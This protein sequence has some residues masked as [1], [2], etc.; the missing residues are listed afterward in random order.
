MKNAFA[1]LW[2]WWAN[3]C[4][5][6]IV[7]ILISFGL[8][9]GFAG[10]GAVLRRIGELDRPTETTKVKGPVSYGI[11]INRLESCPGDVIVTMRSHPLVGD[12]VVVR[13]APSSIKPENLNPGIRP[14]TRVTQFLPSEIGP[15]DWT[16]ESGVQSNCPTRKRWDLLAEFNLKVLP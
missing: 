2:R 12:R 1:N 15:G 10:D 4:G 5:V 13:F 11:D 8:V 3:G 14:T 6:M 7:A 9:E 16:Y